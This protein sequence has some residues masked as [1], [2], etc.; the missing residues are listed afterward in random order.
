LR[1]GTFRCCHDNGFGNTFSRFRFDVHVDRAAK[2]RAI[3]KTD[4]RCGDVAYDVTCLVDSNVLI[5]TNI[6]LDITVDFNLGGVDVGKHTS[7]MADDHAVLWQ[8]D[9]PLHAPS[10]QHISVARGL[11]A[12][13]Q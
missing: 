4:A 10:H 13:D 3:F 9:G 7:V 8:I 6:T 11:T 12:D 5:A 1:S 2:S